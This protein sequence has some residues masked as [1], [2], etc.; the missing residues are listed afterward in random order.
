MNKTMPPVPLYMED[1]GGY[2]AQFPLTCL[3]SLSSSM[4]ELREVCGG[5]SSGICHKRCVCV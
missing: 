3:A 2:V 5:S 1:W 4:V